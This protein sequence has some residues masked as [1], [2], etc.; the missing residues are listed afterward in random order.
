MGDVITALGHTMTVTWLTVKEL[1][2][3][4]D[5]Y[6]KSSTSRTS[7][8]RADA[9]PDILHCGLGR[10]AV[11][12]RYPEWRFGNPKKPSEMYNVETCALFIVHFGPSENNAFNSVMALKTSGDS[13]PNCSWLCYCLFV[14]NNLATS[15]TV[16]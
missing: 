5:T 3:Y 10:R 11:Y 12:S 2:T 9:K 1:H 6:I 15:N 13:T 8:M 14:H 7:S 4:A 16:W